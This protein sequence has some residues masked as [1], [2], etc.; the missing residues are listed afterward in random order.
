MLIGHEG[1]KVSNGP[2]GCTFES[3]CYETRIDS[4]PYSIHDTVG[5]NE[6]DEGRVPHWK[7]IQG[8]YTLIRKLDSVSLLIFCIRGR[9][10]DN[11]H[12][13][14]LFFF[15]AICDKKVP[16]VVVST[17]WEQEENLEEAER[18]LRE[19]LKKYSMDPKAVAC[20]VSIWGRNNEHEEK[21]TQSQEKL[22]KL[23]MRW[24]MTEPWSKDKDEW[25]AQLYQRAFDL[26]LC[27][28]AKTRLQFVEGIR[29]PFQEFKKNGNLEQSD[30]DKLTK[31]LLQ[32]EK[33]VLKKR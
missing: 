24:C 8:L 11:A 33:R 15:D 26:K 13:N 12:A 32:A 21:Y 1:A 19:A 18:Q 27:L 10:R 6:G 17:C 29:L 2:V 16:V 4:M 14:W 22:R 25:F 30:I 31:N 7:A 9:I 20:V 5:L 3:E 28:F 23:T